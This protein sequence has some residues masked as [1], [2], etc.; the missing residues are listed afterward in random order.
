MTILV[1]VRLPAPM[2]VPTTM[3]MIVRTPMPIVRM[4]AS[5]PMT[6]PP[7]GELQHQEH[8]PRRREQTT[9]DQVLVV[10]DR[11]AEAQPDGD[12]HRSEQQ[13]EQDVRARGG[14]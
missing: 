13:R 2:L 4:P 14:Q 1:P 9:H 12:E 8:R 7:P 11:G 10:H 3:T 6:V 5:V